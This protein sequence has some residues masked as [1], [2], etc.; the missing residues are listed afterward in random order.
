MLI[1]F[2]Y[3]CYIQ[4][5]GFLDSVHSSW[6]VLGMMIIKTKA[7]IQLEHQIYTGTVP[8]PLNA[9]NCFRSTIL[10]LCLLYII[11]DYCFL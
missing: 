4:S 8:L 2:L 7:G 9:K 5:V 1:L 3:V 10:I 11:H 6:I